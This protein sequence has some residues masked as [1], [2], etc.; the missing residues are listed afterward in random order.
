MA[1]E[2]IEGGGVDSRSDLFVLG[3]ALYEMVAGRPA[4]NG[5]SLFAVARAIAGAPI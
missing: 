3:A 5:N 4:F 1:P 2:Q